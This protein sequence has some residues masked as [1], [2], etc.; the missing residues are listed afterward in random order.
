M[1]KKLNLTY[2]LWFAAIIFLGTMGVSCK[3]EDPTRVIVTIIDTAGKR[4]DS[5]FV[6]IYGRGTDSA[7]AELNRD[8]ARFYEEMYTNSAGTVELDLTDYTKPGQA[9]FVVLDIEASKDSLKGVGI[10][11]VEE[12]KT[13]QQTVRIQ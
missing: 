12:E 3:K 1:L 10:I 8:K 6:L 2:L 5:A 4:V 9:G 11:N 13:N 7:Q